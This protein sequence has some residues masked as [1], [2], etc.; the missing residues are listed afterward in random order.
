[1]PHL[2]LKRRD[3][4]E[5]ITATGTAAETMELTKKGGHVTVCPRLRGVIKEGEA[6][7]KMCD[8]GRR[9]ARAK[10]GRAGHRHGVDVTTRGVSP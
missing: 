2:A 6:F 10:Q 8:D 4:R 1:V 3:A 5:A 9:T 7:G